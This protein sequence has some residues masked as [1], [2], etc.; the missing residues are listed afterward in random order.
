MF[1]LLIMMESVN[2]SPSGEWR[3]IYSFDCYRIVFHNMILYFEEQKEHHTR[4]IQ[5]K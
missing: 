2:E 1:H 4:Y 3:P 5:Y